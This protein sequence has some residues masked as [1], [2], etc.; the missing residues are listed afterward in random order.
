MATSFVVRAKRSDDDESLKHTFCAKLWNENFYEINQ[1]REGEREREARGGGSPTALRSSTF[2]V[3]FFFHSHNL[4]DQRKCANITTYEILKRPVEKKTRFRRVSIYVCRSGPWHTFLV[5][6]D[7]IFVSFFASYYEIDHKICRCPRPQL[8]LSLE[9]PCHSLLH[10]LIWVFLNRET[11]INSIRIST[12]FNHSTNRRP[13]TSKSN[14][15]QL[16]TTRSL[17]KTRGDQRQQK[18]KNQELYN[19]FVIS[20]L[21]RTHFL[22]PSSQIPPDPCCGNW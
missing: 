11:K 5:R 8:G 6:A 20:K 19:I 1:R 10:K 7:I 22:F 2:Y 3:L 18:N 16:S 9:K 17:K 15:I 4:S 21:A 14:P 13:A 12:V